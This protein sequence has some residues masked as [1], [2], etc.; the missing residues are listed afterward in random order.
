MC[1]LAI[2]HR[3]VEDAPLVVG[4]NREEM[5]ARGGE[6]PRILD[7]A[8]RMLAG[9][10]PTA[11]GTWLGVNQHGVLAAI[12]NRTKSS[13]PARPRS[14]GL[15][16][17]DLLGCA[18]TTE[19]L[20]LACQELSSDRYAGCNVLI[21]SSQRAEVIHAGDW[22]RVRPLSP[23]IHVLAN[24]DVNDASDR[25]I[26][27]AIGWLEQRR[28]YNVDH[29]LAALKELCGQTGNGRPPICLRGS[30]RGTISSTLVAL[31][32]A[33]SRSRYLHA[34]GPP[35]RTPYGDYSSLLDEL[36]PKKTEPKIS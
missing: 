34:Q 33:L 28:Y 12:A 16:V 6:S 26:A 30:D 18:S 21:A 17:R 1:L 36:A 19:A 25:R 15:L 35:D 9:L 5:Y 4:A 24:G 31:E 23:G 32:P 8:P 11:G 22:L 29:S 2:L 10:D 14:R 3:V 7:G 20:K 13:I 27:Y